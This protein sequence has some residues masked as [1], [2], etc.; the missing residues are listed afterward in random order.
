MPAPAIAP[1]STLGA[2][3][4]STSFSG[5]GPDCGANPAL[6]SWVT[7]S[8]AGAHTTDEMPLT[9]NG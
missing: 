7:L 6:S 5:F 4:G 8:V 2:V 3:A 9:E 1:V